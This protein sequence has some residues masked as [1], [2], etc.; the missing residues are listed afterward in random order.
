MATFCQGIGRVRSS[1]DLL[2]PKRASS[3]IGYEHI[4]STVLQMS[5][6]PNLH[7]T[8]E[9]YLDSVR[10]LLDDA[11]YDRMVRLANEFQA[12]EGRSFQRILWLKSWYCCGI[13]LIFDT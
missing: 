11:E 7:Q 5:L 2:V 4:L 1:N 10:P 3:F 12:K 8:C 9:R 6:V 13:T